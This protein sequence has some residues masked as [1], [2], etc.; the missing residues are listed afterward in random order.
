[1]A[2]S[3]KERIATKKKSVVICVPAYN[4]E[5][6]IAKLIVDLKKYSDKIIVVDDGS[7]DYTAKIARELGTVV[8]Q[9][10]KNLGKGA[11]LR[12]CFSHAMT[13]FPDVIVTID[14]DGQ[15]DPACI[16]SLIKPILDKQADVVIGSRSQDT[17]MPR[18]RKIG[19]RPIN[20]LS[21]IAS[22]TNVNDTQSGYRAYSYD[23]IKIV[24]QLR[25]QDYSS[26][27]EQLVVLSE[28]GFVIKE[29]PVQLKY[30]G[31]EKTSKKNFLT[32]GGELILGSFFMIIQRRPII[33]LALPG[34]FL[35]AL[36]MFYGFY[37]ISL[38][39][40][41]R[42]FSMPMSVASGILLIIGVLFVFSSMFIYIITKSKIDLNPR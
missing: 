9:H 16:P 20:Y 34:T 38:F 21:K 5:K 6:S 19:L 33:Y 7:S 8:I 31:L 35:L 42:Y 3:F 36:S 37:T 23:S 27:F 1:L 17:K 40:E 18:Y 14:A 32:H 26:E 15:H 12:S 28:K 10:E 30:D 29:V 22:K 39:N 41:T 11:A 2:T 25:S 4:E 24:A 13:Y